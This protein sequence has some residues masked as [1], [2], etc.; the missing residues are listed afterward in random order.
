MSST[1]GPEDAAKFGLHQTAVQKPRPKNGLSAAAWAAVYVGVAAA[2]LPDVLPVMVGILTDKLGF[3]VV[4]AGYIASVQHVGIVLGTLICA[5]LVQRWS[6]Q[7]LIR[8]GAA[9]LIGTNVLTMLVSSFLPIATMRLVS[10]LGEGVVSAICYAAMGQSGQPARALA[11]Y[12]AGQGLVGAVGMGVIPTIVE[13]AGWPWFFVLVSILA[14][15]AFWLAPS[16]ETLRVKPPSGVTASARTLPWLSWYALLGILV[17]FVGMSAVWTFTERMGRA[18]GIEL[19]H[20]SVALSASALANVAGCL[21]VGLF[22]HRLKIASGLMIGLA[23]ILAGLLTLAASSSWP[24]YLAAVS[25][26]FFA[27]GF[28][29]PFQFKLLAQVDVGGKLTVLTPFVTGGGFILGPAI[30]G[31]LLSAGGT[32]LVSGFGTACVIAS[33]AAALHLNFRS[34]RT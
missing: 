5:A 11:F 14:V 29:Y 8:V 18:K 23:M 6:W 21:L 34:A 25:I 26:F 1:G 30:G 9:V 19:T 3:G 10:G 32:A 28:Y 31:L 4:R 22:A 15:P 20:L 7:A 24:A 33:S 12:L 27:W 17:F 2:T 16:I 13:R